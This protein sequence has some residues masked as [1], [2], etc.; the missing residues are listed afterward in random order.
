MADRTD[1]HFRQKVTEAELDLAF[2][3]LER[4]DRNLAADIGVYGII[5][6]AVPAPHSPVPDLSIDLTAATR[7]Y[8]RLGQRIF[9][10]TDQTVDCTADYSGIPTDVTDAAQERWLGVFLRFDRKLSDLRTDGNSQQ[11][12]FRRDESFE[13]RVRQAPTGVIGNASKVALQADELLICDIHR[14]HGQSQ[15]LADDIDTSRRQAFIFA[16]SDAI[17]VISGL[18]NILQPA[19]NS[20][21]A[22]LD[23]VDVELT[24]HF[25]GSARRHGAANI[26]YTPRGF[27]AAT[28]LQGAVDE[29]IDDLSSGTSI[30]GAARIGADAVSGTPHALP[31]SNV[32][33]QLSQLLAW[34]NQH[35]ST[36][37]GAHSASA[38]AA[39]PHAHIGSTSV[40]AQLQDIV[41]T[42]A[43]QTPGSAGAS[44][45]GTEQVAGAPHQLPAG[46]LASQLVKL[47]DIING[48]TNATSGSHTASAVRVTDTASNY[49]AADTEN[50][51]A[52]VASMFSTEH[53]RASQSAPGQHRTIHQPALGSGRVLL[54]ESAGTGTAHMRLRVQADDDA[55]WFTLNGAWTGSEWTRDDPTAPAGGFRFSGSFFEFLHDQDGT[56]TFTD[57]SNT[58][59]LPMGALVNSSIEATGTVR[60]HGQIGMHGTN[61]DTATRTIALGGA[62][63]FR[64]RFPSTPSSITLTPSNT[65]SNW[66]GSVWL[67]TSSRDGFG[68]YTYQNVTAGAHVWWHGSYDAIA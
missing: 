30:P 8:D 13:I 39:A 26:D 15:I 2:A 6:G 56:A 63:T 61:S 3:L 35:V 10:G 29:L 47:I 55:I 16:T 14:Q 21:Q 68:F 20:V 11:I 12:Y 53:F 1:F 28:D 54:W 49:S 64:A 22:A 48:H 27:I 50:V 36:P 44:R 19:V 66:Q 38:I 24:G 62:T 57:W 65:S 17:E 37:A 52:E 43:A 42:L 31:A 46:T 4:A 7:A 51:L 25:S 67:W 40:Q 23:A 18:W 9:F 32:D 5:S 58:W 33:S 34:V 60:E 41:S 59:R 45:V